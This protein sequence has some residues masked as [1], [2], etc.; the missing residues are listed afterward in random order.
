MAQTVSDRSHPLGGRQEF[1]PATYFGGR[2]HLS[3]RWYIFFC[4]PPGQREY[5]RHSHRRTFHKPRKRSASGWLRQGARRYPLAVVDSD[6]KVN[7]R[8]VTVGDRFG[9]QWVV[10][11]GLKAGERVVAEGVQK[12]R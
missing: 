1:A 5:W 8:T 2:I 12:V 11:D 3:A 4:R 7:I 6:N 10:S 9:N